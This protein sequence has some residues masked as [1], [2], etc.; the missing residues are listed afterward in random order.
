MQYW[1]ALPRMSLPGRM[2]QLD[3]LVLDVV[4]ELFLLCSFGGLRDQPRLV[5]GSGRT[6]FP[7]PQHAVFK[8]GEALTAL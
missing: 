6:W 3:G 8:V 2:C 1:A 7:L 4:G 5:R